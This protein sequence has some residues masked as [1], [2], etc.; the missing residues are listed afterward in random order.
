MGSALL[1]E[2]AQ[3]LAGFTRTAEFRCWGDCVNLKASIGMSHA[4]EGDALQQVLSRAQE[5]A[6]A[7]L[8]AGGNHVTEVKRR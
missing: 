5:T 7:S 8:H 4:I 2:H 3:R 6:H 1:A